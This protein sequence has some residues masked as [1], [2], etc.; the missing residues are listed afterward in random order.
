MDTHTLSHGRIDAQEVVN[1]EVLRSEGAFDENDVLK[2]IADRIQPYMGMFSPKEKIETMQK[3]RRFLGY[4]IST[5]ST[6]GILRYVGKGKY[7][8]INY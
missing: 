8:V 1:S 7:R 3:I 5:Y 2:R 4:V 6:H